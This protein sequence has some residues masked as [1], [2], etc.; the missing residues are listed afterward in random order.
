MVK[1]RIKFNDKVEHEL[2]SKT[3]LCAWF[4]MEFLINGRKLPSYM[5]IVKIKTKGKKN[6]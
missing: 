5:S 6:E 1:Y 3:A 2:E 4:M